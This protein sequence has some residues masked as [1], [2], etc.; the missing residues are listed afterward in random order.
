MKFYP[1]ALQSVSGKTQIFLK[2]AFTI[3][4]RPDDLGLLTR[5]RRIQFLEFEI[6]NVLVYNSTIFKLTNLFIL[7]FSFKTYI[8]TKKCL[9]KNVKKL[10]IRGQMVMKSHSFLKYCKW[11][12]GYFTMKGMQYART[13]DP[14]V[15]VNST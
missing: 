12:L 3:Q 10:C 5:V 11:E 1:K 8:P 13:S 2:V 15:K 7:Y 6:K 14:S 9:R 4:Y